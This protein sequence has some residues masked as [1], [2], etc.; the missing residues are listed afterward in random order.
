MSPLSEY[1]AY[2]YL[3]TVLSNYFVYLFFICTFLFLHVLFPL[4]EVESP[5]DGKF[6]LVCASGSCLL[7]RVVSKKLSSLSLFLNVLLFCPVFFLHLVSFTHTLIP[8]FYIQTNLL[9]FAVEFECCWP[10]EWQRVS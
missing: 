1:E 4:D 7:R 10:N 3:S 5:E 9:I 2:I 6:R 8:L